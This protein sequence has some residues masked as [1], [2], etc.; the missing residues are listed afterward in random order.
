[1]LI[2]CAWFCGWYT[3]RNLV[4]HAGCC[5]VLSVCALVLSHTDAGSV[6]KCCLYWW[7]W[8][9]CLLWQFVNGHM[10]GFVLCCQRYSVFFFIVSGVGPSP[11][12][13]GHFWP[14]V[15]TP[16]DRWLWSNWWNEDWQGKPKYLEKTCPSTTLST[17]NPTWAMAQ[18]F[19]YLNN[20]NTEQNYRIITECNKYTIWV[21]RLGWQNKISILSPPY[22]L[23]VLTHST[24]PSMAICTAD[25]I[26]TCMN[27]LSAIWKP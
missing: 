11:L 8:D 23:H 21:R 10:L 5:H 24:C 25:Y 26:N 7:I 19:S 1:M 16:D 3:E 18:P 13:C 17:T 27:V 9:A 22:M 2:T 6:F 4:V 20:I 14:I 12:Y 15:P